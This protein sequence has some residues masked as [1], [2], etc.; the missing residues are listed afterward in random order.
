M[1]QYMNFGLYT[2]RTIA[3]KS[4][5]IVVMK[6]AFTKFI[7]YVFII[8]ILEVPVGYAKFIVA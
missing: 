1:L 4:E 2:E 3:D 8:S 6:R 7:L 5:T